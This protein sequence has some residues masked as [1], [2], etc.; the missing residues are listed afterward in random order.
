MYTPAP[1]DGCACDSQSLHL[2]N[3]PFVLAQ[4]PK[5]NGPNIWPLSF[6]CSPDIICESC[7]IN[8]A[9]LHKN[10][11]V[12]DEFITYHLLPAHTCKIHL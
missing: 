2:T 7:N 8:L 3:Y 12:A 10:M 11:P 5:Q 4:V 6:I 1:V 9:M